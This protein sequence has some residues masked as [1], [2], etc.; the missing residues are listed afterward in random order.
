MSGVPHRVAAGVEGVRVAGT[1]SSRE[2]LADVACRLRD[3]PESPDGYPD[4]SA[5]TE[6]LREYP[7]SRAAPGRTCNGPAICG[8][9][10][11]RP[12]NAYGSNVLDP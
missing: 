2:E 5:Y 9:R 11:I 4:L 3:S 1:R 12:A 6:F 10:R 7:T 8:S